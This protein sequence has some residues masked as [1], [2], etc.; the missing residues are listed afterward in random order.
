MTL[1]CGRRLDLKIKTKVVI[2]IKGLGEEGIGVSK[3][4]VMLPLL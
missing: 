4:N 1:L 2:C 3:F